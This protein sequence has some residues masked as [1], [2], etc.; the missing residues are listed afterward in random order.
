MLPGESGTF[1]SFYKGSL[2]LGWTIAIARC[3][4]DYR[5]LVLIFFRRYRKSSNFRY[6]HV[7]WW[8]DG[9]LGSCGD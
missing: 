4:S 3:R 7:D 1:E 2:H 8:L 5:R 9:V 6:R